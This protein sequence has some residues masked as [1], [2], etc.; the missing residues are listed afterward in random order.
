MAACAGLNPLC[1]LM[2][3]TDWNG[4]A[5]ETQESHLAA[6]KGLFCSSPHRIRLFPGVPVAGGGKR[7]T[8]DGDVLVAGPGALRG[9]H[10]RAD[11]TQ[12]R[13]QGGPAD[14][15]GRTAR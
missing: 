12:A 10:R 4:A 8:L 9:W 2:A 6:G 14:L 5:R 1:R 11:R 15:V 7:G 3:W 13:G